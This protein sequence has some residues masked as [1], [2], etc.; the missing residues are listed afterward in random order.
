MMILCKNFI[1]FIGFIYFNLFVSIKTEDDIPMCD[2]SNSQNWQIY[3]G[4]RILE[5]YNYLRITNDSKEYVDMPL[6]FSP[7]ETVNNFTKAFGDSKSE[8][9]NEEKFRDFLGQHF[10][11]AG[12]E[13][14]NCTPDGFHDNPEKLMAIRDPD[15]R[16]WALQLNA[17][18][19]RLCKQMDKKVSKNPEKYSLLP[20]KHKFI[21]P[22][23]RFREPYYWDAYWIVKGLM[24]SELYEAAK[25]MIQNFAD[26]VNTYGFIPNGGR[27]Y[28]LQRSQP[29]MFTP[30]IYE[31]YENTH[32][33]AFIKDMLPF[34]EKEFQYWQ[35][36][37]Q[38]NITLGNKMYT[39]YQWRAGSNMPRPESYK[40]DIA[41]AAESS[42]TDKQ[43]IYRDLAS[44]AESGQD[45]STR[46]FADQKTIQ[47]IETT[48][49]LPVDL[50]SFLCWNMDILS[51]FFDEI[52][53]DDEK[54]EKY[55]NI[56]ASHRRAVH[57]VFYNETEKMWLDYNLRSGKHNPT[58]YAT[59]ATPLF[60]NCYNSLD[61]GK[62]EGV[63]NFFNRSHAFD[64]PNGVPSSLI[65]ETGEQ[66]DYPNGWGNVNHMIIE[67]LRKSEAPAAQDVAFSLATRWVRG[68]FKVYNATKHMWEK[69]D[70]AG[71]V[72]IPGK[73]GE[74]DVQDGFGWTNGAILDLLVTYGDRITAFDKVEGNPTP[75]T[76][77]DAST[78]QATP[79]SV[80]PTISSAPPHF[81]ISLATLFFPFILAF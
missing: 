80:S 59:L 34:M 62:A 57:A 66:W 51:Y 35:N 19:K 17:I 53:K 12:H 61:Q 79:P 23:G 40:E 5:T 73:G 64:F 78:S 75:P 44:A 52:A 3:C 29:P 58:F 21:A 38:Y 39:V 43:K 50:N 56:L 36:K 25:Q 6:I 81:I 74:Y 13:L 45:F 47:T 70:V 24:A 26:F 71:S 30:M 20:L 1:I 54:S 14:L 28:Y 22:G 15:L 55:R 49:I 37:H 32:D 42:L 46:W 33:A 9:I 18:W 68:N 10:L 41:T 48:N 72:P 27:V 65:R 8:D 76:H 63:F 2:S 7:N 31:L 4:G 67:G 69:Y 16:E 60:T 11:P 77:A